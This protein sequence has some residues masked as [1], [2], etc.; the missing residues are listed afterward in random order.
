M[1]APALTLN[2]AALLRDA[3]Y[4]GGAWTPA[5]A[6]EATFA[7]DDPATGRVLARLPDAGRL[8]AEQALDAAEAAWP[9]WRA[10]TGK[11]R[12]QVLRRWFD[13][14]VRH[15][16]DLA[17]LISA[18]EGKPLAEA[19][20]ETAYGASFVEWF[21]EQAK[22]VDGDILQSPQPDKRILAI[23]QPVG[24][25]AAITPWN[26][27]L[28]MITRKAAP[29]LAAGCTIVIKPAEQTPLTALALAE[30]AGRAGVPPGV[31]NVLTADSRQSVAVGE[32]LTTDPRVR[33]VSFTGSTEVGRILMR[34]CSSTVKKV[35]LELGGHA[36][37]IV[38]DDAD[39]DAA[40]EGALQAKYRNAGQACIAPNRYY[41]QDGIHDRFVEAVAR[42]SAALR[43]GPAAEAGAEIGP[44]ID[45]A[46]L[47]KVQRHVDDARASGATVVTG[48]QALQGNFYAPSVLSGVTPGMLISREETFGPV[49]GV[50]RFRDESEI[51]ALANHPEYGLA[52]YLYTRD[53]GRIWR[54]SEALEFGMVGIN[55][56]AISNE[57]GP[58]GGIKQSGLGREGSR[59]GID[60]YLEMKYLCMGGLGL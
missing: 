31:L 23:R 59:Y 44:L 52:A 17:A 56:G 12:A 22:R 10:L 45:R 24:V 36:P 11:A 54:V 35:A 50:T 7:V 46:A 14:I 58:F 55:T 53:M 28:A 37:F 30:L 39:L 21:A 29:A 33:H 43:V 32:V 8:H 41:V 5:Q 16:E 34:Q 60:E 18:E 20:A 3:M 40:V 27:P 2:D 4:I 47:D 26:F 25:C 49:I 48:G 13:L 38:F 19:R 57:V 15:G 9:A 42:R 1:N 51:A 6:G